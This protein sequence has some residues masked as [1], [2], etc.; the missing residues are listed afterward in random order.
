[1]SAGLTPPMQRYRCECQQVFQFFGGGRHRRFYE[2]DDVGCE[3]P[4]M[5]GICPSCERR[6]PVTRDHLE[7]DAAPEG[8]DGSTDELDFGVGDAVVSPHHG[9]GTVVGRSVRELAGG[10]REYLTI[11]LKRG[12][13]T[14]MIPA[15][16]ASRLR[17]R[18]VASSAELRRGLDTLSAAPEP[19]SGNWQNRH[20][21]ALTKLS[22]GDVVLLAQVVRD[23]AHLRVAKPL[24][25]ADRQ[26]YTKARELLECELGVVLRVDE[27]W[28]ADQIDRRLPGAAGS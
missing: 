12:S 7:S 5:T 4:V 8:A 2:L 22:S 6:L 1:M 26:L 18:P 15:E 23:L 9:V 28:A 20:R 14:L 19:L 13:M 24:G 27:S 16:E 17:L 21:E 25:L 11:E 3:R 10:R